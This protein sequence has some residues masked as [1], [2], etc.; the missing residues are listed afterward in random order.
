MATY[1]AN[2]N[3]TATT[4]VPLSTTGLRFELTDHL[5]TVRA[6]ITGHLSKQGNINIVS[7][8]D[9]Y[10]YGMD[11]PG[12]TYVAEAYR[13]GYQG[14]ERDND[15]AGGSGYTTPCA[16]VEVFIFTKNV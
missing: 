15:L 10:P 3:V 7:L 13:Y 16:V 5:G 2:T 1:V 9:Y 6:V 4:V 11:M 14:S 12:R 8:A